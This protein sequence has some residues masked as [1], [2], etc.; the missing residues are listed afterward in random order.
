MPNV[1]LETG[2]CLAFET[3]KRDLDFMKPLDQ[4]TLYGQSSLLAKALS[5]M[6][7]SRDD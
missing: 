6:M 2:I 1:D 4:T 7:H 3:V 5:I